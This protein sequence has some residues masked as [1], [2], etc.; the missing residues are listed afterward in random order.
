M[1]KQYCTIEDIENYLLIEISPEFEEQVEKWISAVSKEMDILANRVLV[2]PVVGSGDEYESK[3]YDGNNDRYLSIDDCQS[4]QEVIIGEEFGDNPVTLEATDYVIN[5]KTPPIS[6]II[7]KTSYFPL[8]IQNITIKGSFGLMAEITDDLSL[9]CAV[10]V[11]GIINS[12]NNDNQTKKSES[13]GSYSVTYGDEKGFSD[14]EGALNT[15]NSY[16][17]IEY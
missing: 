16:R 14:Y 4:I 13:I 7:L 5:P 12:Q 2:A 1:E 10:L 17:K 6:Q 9:A 11:A 3:Y 15:I 8:G